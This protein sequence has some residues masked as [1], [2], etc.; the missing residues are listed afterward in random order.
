M[1]M[2]YQITHIRLSDSNAT[3]TDKITHIKL[4]GDLTYTIEDI[5][6]LLKDP[7]H[8]HLFYVY[9]NIIMFTPSI[10]AVYPP[11]GKPYIRTESNPAPQD[12]LLSLRRF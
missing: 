11:S 7:S 8:Y 5:V 1:V 3:S 9:Q 6:E 12:L 2:S 4:N 10:E